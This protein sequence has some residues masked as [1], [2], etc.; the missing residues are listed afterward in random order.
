MDEF[1]HR[2]SNPKPSA[3]DTYSFKQCKK[4]S[5]TTDT[6]SIHIAI[7]LKIDHE[8]WRNR[9]TEQAEGRSDVGCSA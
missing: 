9:D 5:E 6:H 1:L 2:L 8:L 4:D 3:L 7:I